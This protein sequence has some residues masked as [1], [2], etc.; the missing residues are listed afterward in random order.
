MPPGGIDD[1]PSVGSKETDASGSHAPAAA[2]SP[3]TAPQKLR[4]LLVEDHAP[5][6]AILSL[7]LER[8]GYEV[9]TADSIAEALA[10]LAG[11]MFDLL[12]SDLSLP[13]GNGA[14]L[15]Q[16]IRRR[17]LAFPAIAMTGYSEQIDFATTKDAGFCMHLVK[18]VDLPELKVAIDQALSA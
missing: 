8:D 2:S 4:I 1:H 11:R 10:H 15:L 5:T 13:D 14:E 9:A 12:I 16:E 3:Q 17:T 6:L 18:P 7:L